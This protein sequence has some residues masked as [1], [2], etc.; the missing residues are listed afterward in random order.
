MARIFQDCW[1][2]TSNAPSLCSKLMPLYVEQMHG[3]REPLERIGAFGAEA[4][5]QR[6]LW[7]IPSHYFAL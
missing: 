2:S 5:L 3:E 1:E 6:N 4:K 7:M